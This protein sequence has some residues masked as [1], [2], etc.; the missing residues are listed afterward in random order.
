MATSLFDIGFPKGHT[1]EVIVSTYGR[2][3][4]PN[5]AP[6]GMNVEDPQLFILR[7]FKTSLTFANLRESKCGVANIV[8]DPEVFYRTAFKEANQNGEIPSEWFRSADTVEAPTLAL[9]NSYVEF[10]V[11]T[12]DERKDEDSAFVRC[13]VKLIKATRLYANPY[14]RS[15]FATIE[16]II[17]ATRI[18]EYFSMNRNKDAEA[19][20]QLVN[21]YR[22]LVARIS[23]NSNYSRIIDDLMVSIHRWRQSCAG[24]R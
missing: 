13:A 11:K 7:P 20:I 12:I 24:V 6:M 5:A 19:L 23:P 17:H 10:A 8:F 21:H 15:V 16:C 3:R 18:R 9:A 4:V 1:Y 22:D 2:S 14:C